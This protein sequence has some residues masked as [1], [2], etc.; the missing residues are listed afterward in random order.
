[1]TLNRMIEL[2]E[3]EHECM[4]RA[5]HDDCDRKCEDCVLVQDDYDLHEMY[6]NVI[7]IIDNLQKLPEV[8]S[9]RF[10]IPCDLCHKYFS[11]YDCPN[12][13]DS[14]NGK[15]HWEMLIERIMNYGK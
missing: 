7:A 3:I 1:M 4:L 13:V 8:L 11:T 9:R 14:C 2:L 12:E 5:S 10:C 15:A 6:T